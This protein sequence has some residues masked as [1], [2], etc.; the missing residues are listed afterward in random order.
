MVTNAMNENK[1]RMGDLGVGADLAA[2]ST[3]EPWPEGGKEGVVWERGGRS[4]LS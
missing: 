1:A 3:C 4:T 2:E